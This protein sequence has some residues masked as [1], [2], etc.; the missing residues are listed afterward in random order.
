MVHHK[1]TRGTCENRI[2]NSPAELLR[3]KIDE[4]G[5]THF[6][7]AEESGI[8][9]SLV[10]RL[11]LADKKHPYSPSIQTIGAVVEVLGITDKEL[12]ELVKLFGNIK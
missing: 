4:K 2:Y 10:Q 11:L 1:E 8:S 7:L 12:A 9:T 5:V 3:A 6:K